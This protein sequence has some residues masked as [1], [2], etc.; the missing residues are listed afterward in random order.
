MPPQ[1]PPPPVPWLPDGLLEEVFLRLPPD[2]PACLVRASLANKLWLGLLSGARFR[3]RYREF[4]G[5]A[6]MLG[7]LYNTLS[8]SGPELE[9]DAP[10]FFST[11]KFGA[12]IP[13][14][15]WKDYTACD[16]RH[17]RALLCEECAGPEELIVW[18]PVTGCRTDLDAPYDVFDSYGAVVLCAVSGCDHRACHEG[19]FRVAFVG[20][21]DTEVGC[22]IHSFMSNQLSYSYRSNCD[23]DE[24]EDEDEWVETCDLELAGH[25]HACIV[26]MRPVLVGGVLYFMFFLGD[27]DDIAILCYDMGSQGLSL[28]HLPDL[29]SNGLS[30]GDGSFML[31]EN[32]DGSLGFAHMHRL[33]LYLWSRQMSSV[34]AASWS[35]HRVIDLKGSLPIQNPEERPDLMGSVEGRD[36]IFVTTDLGIYQINLKTLRWKKLWKREEFP[37]LIPYMS[38][39]NPP[40]KVSPGDAIH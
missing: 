39:Y 32:V 7:F 31:M 15:H 26:P 6:P 27:D 13:F 17:G 38:F 25:Q 33:I 40:E 29:G 10:L 14:N 24:D 16:C 28:I 21:K 5:D 35:Q 3:S 2:E 1:P 20:T 30:L 11:T 36:I 19:P 9:D 8:D 23:E 18:D 22:V 12:R 4:H 37:I 34:G